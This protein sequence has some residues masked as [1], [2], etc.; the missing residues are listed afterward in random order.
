MTDMPDGRSESV[1]P[2]AHTRAPRRWPYLTADMPGIGGRI[3][4]R[5]EDFRVEEL[6]LYEACGEGAHVYFRVVKSGVPTPV[7]VDRI[8]RHM[9]V[10]PREIGVA[11]LKDA[12]AITTQMMSLEHADAE[13]LAAFTDKQVR[14]VWTGRHTNKLRPGHLAGNRFAIRIRGVG[15]GHLD[16]AQGI[17]NVLVRRGVP[18]YFGPQR[19]GARFDT[20][21]LGQAMV[22]GDPDEF[23]AI[24]LG[25]A[26]PDDPPD[27]KAA[28]D[29]F[30]TGFHNRALRCWPRHY[31]NERR[32]LAAY[33]KKL[34]PAAALRA[35]D[36]R[37]RRL[38]VSAFQSAIF[39]DVLACRLAT[40]DR[41]L[42]GDLAR[43]GQT[44]GIFTVEDA[45]AEQPRADAFEISPTGPMVGYRSSLASGEPG[46]IERQM[47]AAHE[48]TQEDF[49]HVGPLKVKGTRRA[50]RFALQAPVL[51]AGSDAHGQYVE[52]AFTAPSGCYATAVLRE[53]MKTD[54][55]AG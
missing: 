26:S 30:D 24:F 49:R 5:L 32:A 9:G 20:A 53:I 6:A 3:K 48:V 31:A 25:R 44:G 12:R 22:T 10:R 36:K 23:I 27:C 54:P 7:A 18:S 52:L 46:R 47:M 16:A 29:A 2:T 38:Y 15:A 51:S 28:R 17:L 45:E 55:Q 37:M 21:A 33:K 50:L 1:D 4:E 19:F 40:I 42:V 8:A 35:I 34:D 43:K 13:R 41:V 11:G 14:I 39:N